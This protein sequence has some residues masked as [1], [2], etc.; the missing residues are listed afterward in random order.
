MRS[1][2]IPFRRHFSGEFEEKLVFVDVFARA[3]SYSVYFVV[4][5]C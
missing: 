4:S 2:A 5:V 3:C 1:F